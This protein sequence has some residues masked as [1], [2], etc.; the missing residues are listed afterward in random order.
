[1][2]RSTKPAHKPG[3][4]PDGGQFAAT[5]HSDLVPEL[6]VPIRI[7]SDP[8]LH[9]AIYADRPSNAE[10]RGYG[11]RAIEQVLEGDDFNVIFSEE[12]RAGIRE[13]AARDDAM[14]RALGKN[15]DT[16]HH[17]GDALARELAALRE[18]R[19]AI[20]SHYVPTS[21]DTFEA[22]AAHIT[23]TP[24]EYR[25]AIR[26]AMPHLP[27]HW[28]DGLLA[29]QAQQP[30]SWQRD[31]LSKAATA[32]EMAAALNAD[33]PEVSEEEN[34]NFTSHPVCPLESRIDG[35]IFHRGDPTCEQNI[36][37]LAGMEGAG[38]GTVNIKILAKKRLAAWRHTPIETTPV[39]EP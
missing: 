12:A 9:A 1:M 6:G 35:L 7:P 21:A 11:R 30:E 18:K 17:L 15:W 22:A 36:R 10:R 27:E 28:V 14:D 23:G 13:E 5:A 16:P 24:E 20:E 31:Q 39:G 3:G 29:L 25:T 2:S 34:P 26:E 4:T 38:Y 33:H 32:N 37:F 19:L 8:S